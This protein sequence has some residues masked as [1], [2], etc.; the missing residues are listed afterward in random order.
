[1]EANEA[2]VTLMPLLQHSHLVLPAKP[3]YFMCTDE[4]REARRAKAE[5]MGGTLAWAIKGLMECDDNM[6]AAMKWVRDFAP[7]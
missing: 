2:A 5:A 7:R 6:D 1:M 4:A 3:V